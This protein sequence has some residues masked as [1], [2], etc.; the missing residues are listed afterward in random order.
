[1][2]GPGT[3]TRRGGRRRAVGIVVGLPVA[4]LVG[5]TGW[6][7][8]RGALAVRHLQAAAAAVPAIRTEVMAGDLAAARPRLDRFTA[9]SAAAARLTGDPV[10]AAA[11]RLPRVGDDLAAVRT[12]A[13]V[14]ARIATGVVGPLTG[15]AGLGAMS[16]ARSDGAGPAPMVT[17]LAAARAPMADAQRQLRTAAAEL[18]TVDTRSLDPRVA[19]PTETLRDRLGAADTDLDAAVR[20]SRVLP[21]MLGGTRPRTYLVLFQNLAEARSLG[22]VP[23][24]FAVVRAQ[25]GTVSLVAQGSSA[26]VGPF[27][28]PVL[29]LD[30]AYRQLLADRTGRY[31]QDVTATPWF[32]DTA[33][34]AREMWRRTSGQQVDGVVATD[35]VMLARLMAVTGPIR[36]PD[37]GTVGAGGIAQLVQHDVYYRYP[38][39]AAQDRF[40]AGTAAAA[41][42]S[43][44]RYRGD[45]VALVRAASAGIAE[46]RL[47]VWDSSP[48]VE[49]GLTGTVLAGIPA[50]TAAP[51]DERPFVGVYLNDGTGSKMS[52][53]LRR[54]VR[55]TEG[56][57]R[58]DG[59]RTLRVRLALSSTAPAGG[60][61]GYVTGAGRNGVRPGTMRMS[62][63]VVGSGGGGVVAARVDGRGTPLGAYRLH[64]RPLG[65]LTVD[66]LPGATRTVEFE[67]VAPPGRGSPR[68]ALQPLVR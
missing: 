24:A 6:L 41:F 34:L 39:P 2:T 44:V 35:P 3:A 25:R 15:P 43:L 37:G 54:D 23:S 33:R 45:P 26:D 19:V 59:G 9:D 63:W 67:L 10:W 66:L 53:Y 51:G 57:R 68:V 61:P 29:D 40:F 58:A 11:T 49:A 42:G 12:V 48:A 16:A 56:P 21:A 7:G 18:A 36:L 65:A 22:G 55:V 52:W 1:M 32:P 28:P 46:G 14:G 64:G 4:A 47:L 17:A 13:S 5:V 27:D 8:V 31:L 60:L 38:D 50:G 20:A 62:V 30:P